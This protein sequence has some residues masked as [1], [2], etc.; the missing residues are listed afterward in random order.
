MI[1][2]LNAQILN[3]QKILEGIQADIARYEKSLANCESGSPPA[4]Q[5]D[6]S[7]S[8]EEEGATANLCDVDQAL[9]AP[10]STENCAM[11]VSQRS[12]KA[13]SFIYS[14]NEP[15]QIHVPSS[16]TPD[17]ENTKPPGDSCSSMNPVS[18]RRARKPPAPIPLRSDNYYL[19]TSN[20]G[21]SR[22]G[23]NV[24]KPH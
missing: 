9:S 6:V 24:P 11:P 21:Y 17:F 22:H 14:D 1:K 10:T 3:E 5:L 15:S 18:F 7:V 20:R 8:I 16:R 13:T 19:Q 12:G 23:S 4:P 2:E